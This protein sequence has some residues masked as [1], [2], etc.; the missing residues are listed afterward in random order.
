MCYLTVLLRIFLIASLTLILLWYSLV[1]CFF[2][3]V[4]A[5]AGESIDAVDE[6][7][8]VHTFIPFLKLHDE[9]ILSLLI[10][11]RFVIS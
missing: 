1:S 3:K 2:Q 9:I 7:S 4:L 10:I 5:D 6:V 11:T 8:N